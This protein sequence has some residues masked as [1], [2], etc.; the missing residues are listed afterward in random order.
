MMRR[1]LNDLRSLDDSSS[2]PVLIGL[3]Y[4]ALA[5]VT[6]NPDPFEREKRLFNAEMQRLM[7]EFEA[8][9][10]GSDDPLETALKLAAAGNI[11]DFGNMRHVD[12]AV[13]DSAVSKVRE[14]QIPGAEVQSLKDELATARTLLY[15][16][17]NAGEIVLDKLLLQHIRNRFPRLRVYFGTR[18]RPV[19]NDATEEDAIAVGIDEVATV[20]SNG[21]DLPG[22]VLAECSP[23]FRALFDEADVVIAKG[24]GNFE[25]L[26]EE[27]SRN[28]YFLFI[29]KNDC[30]VF[31]RYGLR[32]KD[33]VLIE[34]RRPPLPE[35]GGPSPAY[36]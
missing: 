34:N 9:V 28:V 27:A 35:G 21:S 13:L 4:R 11:I 32:V 33:L 31:R 15:I 2:P 1:V 6:G 25:G 30:S 22:V 20:V 36:R 23:R 7:P 10:E 16:G 18:G 3:V 17:D 29:S 5:A 26:K 12:R 24:M 8:I 19:I 14:S